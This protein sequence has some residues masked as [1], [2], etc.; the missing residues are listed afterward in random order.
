MDAAKYKL[1]CLQRVVVPTVENLRQQGRAPVFMQDG[2]RPHTAHANL[3]YL[4][5]KGVLIIENWPARSP[6]LNPIENLWALIQRKVSDRGPT[7]EEE[8]RAMVQEEWDAIPQA[9][10][11]E[12]VLSFQERLEECRRVKGQHLSR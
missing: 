2:A 6:E 5:S 3:A 4:G 8:L 11:D 1:H 7:D 10:I 12:Y 9:L